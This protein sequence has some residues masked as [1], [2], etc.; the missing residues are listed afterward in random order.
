MATMLEI[1]MIAVAISAIPAQGYMPITG[2]C[3]SDADCIS[4]EGED[5]SCC[6]QWNL[7]MPVRVCKPLREVG[8]VCRVNGAPFP[9]VGAGRQT[10]F[11][12]CHQGLS[13]LRVQGQVL[14][15]RC[16]GPGLLP[17]AH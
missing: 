17:A 11:C 8:D 3:S 2:F 9:L 12:P 13:C 16:Q 4:A 15:G 7:G 1:L 6:A 5:V 10:T 14:V